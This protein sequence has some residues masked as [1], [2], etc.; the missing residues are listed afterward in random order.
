[1]YKLF[2]FLW[3]IHT[4]LVWSHVWPLFSHA[5]ALR[6]WA[7]KREDATRRGKDTGTCR[8]HSVQPFGLLK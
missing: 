3:G 4:L 5:P 2:F 6:S 7:R 8:T 1:M